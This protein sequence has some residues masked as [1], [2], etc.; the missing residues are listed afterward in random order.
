MEEKL[1]LTE[2]IVTETKQD[3]T[4]NSDENIDIEV[5]KKFRLI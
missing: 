5:K 4:D 2:K 3:D 1:D